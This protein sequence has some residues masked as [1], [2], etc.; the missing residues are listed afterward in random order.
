MRA[1]EIWRD[2]CYETTTAV[3][4]NIL[5]SADAVTQFSVD[6]VTNWF[7]FLRYLLVD[8]NRFAHLLDWA[9]VLARK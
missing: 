2:T 1:T 8:L 7:A 9:Q 6:M 5:D 3:I 4:I